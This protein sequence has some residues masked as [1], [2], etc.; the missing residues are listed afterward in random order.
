MST[1][2]YAQI[3]PTQ[4]EKD[5]LKKYID[6]NDIDNIL[7]LANKLYS[8]N[9]YNDKCKHNALHLG[10]RSSGWQFLWC[11][12]YSNY[13]DLTKQSLHDFIF[14]NDVIIYNEYGEQQDKQEFWNM[15]LTWD[16]IGNKEYYKQHK[17]EYYFDDNETIISEIINKYNIN[18]EYGEFYNDGL[19]FSIY[20]DFV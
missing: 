4:E 10:K 1:N 18:P 6:E 15:A 3:L 13:Y 16:G 17:D 19:R 2:Y 8:Y 11:H 14:R 12:N 7:P 9:Y 5:Q 20:D